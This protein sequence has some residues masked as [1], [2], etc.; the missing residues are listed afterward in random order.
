[1]FCYLKSMYLKYFHCVI[2][3]H[4][5]GGEHFY[6]CD[7]LVH[8]RNQSIICI[9]IYIILYFFFSVSALFSSDIHRSFKERKVSKYSR[10]LLWHINLLVW[11]QLW[12]YNPSAQLWY[13]YTFM[14][15]LKNNMNVKEQTK[16]WTDFKK[17]NVLKQRERI[18][19]H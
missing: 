13:K 10:P 2:L 7:A 8:F 14:K 6:K 17:A 4:R 9:Y 12:I 1:M 5:A 3:Q 16:L 15:S 18:L 19:N 11:F